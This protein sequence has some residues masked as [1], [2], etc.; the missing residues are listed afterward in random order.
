MKEKGF[1]VYTFKVALKYDKRTW[2]RIEIAAS[3]T[4]DDLHEAVFEAFDRD[5]EHL[6]SFYFCDKPTSKSYNRHDNA[7]E[8]K[9][10][11]C[12]DDYGDENDEYNAAEAR[13]C[14]LK[15]KEKQKFEYLFDFGDCWWHE[16]TFEGSD[17][18]DGGH[19]PLIMEKRGDSP[20]QYPDYEDDDYW[21][22]EKVIE[23]TQ[24]SSGKEPI[25]KDVPSKKIKAATKKTTP[26]KKKKKKVVK[27]QKPD[28]SP[29]DLFSW[30]DK[31]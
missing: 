25:K 5:D 6:Y 8:Y 23:I 22:D 16:L 31:S 12:F 15:L 13:L 29:P 10:P 26:A 7:V 4:L 17:R 11:M 1:E 9:H 21:D 18:R 24:I 20:P 2:R 30:S 3:Q 19:Y 14:T 27:K 28:D